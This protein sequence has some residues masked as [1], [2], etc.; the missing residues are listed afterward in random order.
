LLLRL[1]RVSDDAS[2]EEDYSTALAIS[3]E[4]PESFGARRRHHS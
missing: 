4:W 3:R 2:A 1:A